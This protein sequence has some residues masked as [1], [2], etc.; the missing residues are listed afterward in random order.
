MQIHIHRVSSYHVLFSHIFYISVAF[1]FCKPPCPPPPP[2]S[3]LLSS[4]GRPSSQT[5]FSVCPAHGD[6]DVV[7]AME[8]D[9]VDP[10]LVPPVAQNNDGTNA[11]IAIFFQ[12]MSRNVRF[13]N[14]ISEFHLKCLSFSM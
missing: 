12:A 5:R 1:S 2:P 9:D 8:V 7:K 14:D 13:V 6:N 3:Q 10:Q 11:T 4:L